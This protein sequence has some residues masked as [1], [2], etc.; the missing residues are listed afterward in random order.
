MHPIILDHMTSD[1]RGLYKNNT[2]ETTKE[3]RCNTCGDVF[4]IREGTSA[5][6]INYYCSVCGRNYFRRHTDP[7]TIG[8]FL[9]ECGGALHNYLTFAVCP[10]CGSQDVSAPVREEIG[11]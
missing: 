3:F 9:C 6:G 2:L 7:K 1:T 11:K 8:Y 5:L 10:K 4:R